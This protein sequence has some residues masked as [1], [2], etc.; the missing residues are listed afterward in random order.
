MR[1]K[2]FLFILAILITLAF[3]GQAFSA[4]YT[5]DNANRLLSIDHGNGTVIN[6]TYDAAGN[7]T[8]MTVQHLPVTIGVFESGSWYLDV[9]GNGVWDGTPTDSM[10]TFGNGLSGAVPVT[11]NWSGIGST[12]IGVFADGTWYLDMNGN[13]AWDGTPTDSIYTFGNGLAGAVPVTGDWNGSGTT[14]IGVYAGG[15]WYLD[16]NGNGVWDG[17]PY[18]TVYTFGGEH[19]GAVPVTEDW[20]GSATTK[21]GV[22][23]GGYW[24]LDVNGNGA[25]DGTPTDIIYAFG[26]QAGAV[27]V[28][29][30]WSG[31]GMT[32]I[33]I[34]TNGTWY[35]DVNGNGAWD[36]AP[37]DSIYTFGDGLTGAVPVTGRWN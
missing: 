11:G 36:G 27:A 33:C 10:Y 20:G 26:G 14:K 35:L 19:A 23:A 1:Y 15:A 13:G 16:T 17:T 3:S 5:Y 37:P 25:W 34:F 21:I 22:Y 7:R 31:T 12:K 9:N 24:Y 32:K 30:D 4:T 6:Y 29:G 18:D 2:K 28:T 8:S